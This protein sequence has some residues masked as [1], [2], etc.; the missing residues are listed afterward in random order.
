MEKK[1]LAIG[2]LMRILEA[3]QIK[4]WDDWSLSYE[5]IRRHDLIERAAEALFNEISSWDNIPSRYDI[6]CG[7]GNNG[8]DGLA[9]AR[10]LREQ[11]YNVSVILFKHPNE[12]SPEF[13]EQY[14]HWQNVSDPER[15]YLPDD[16]LPSYEKESPTVAVT[17]IDALLGNGINRKPEGRILDLIKHINQTY[18]R[19]ASIDLPSGL[20]AD[21]ET[22]YE[23]G[24]KIEDSVQA[25]ELLVVE[26]PKLTLLFPETAR[27]IPRWNL[28]SLSMSHEF[29]QQTDS[30]WFWFKADSLRLRVEDRF[31][32]KGN[33]LKLLLVGGQSGMAGAVTLAASAALETGIGLMKVL[34]VADARYSLMTH[35][36]EAILLPSPSTDILTEFPDPSEFGVVAIGPGLGTNPATGNALSTFLQKVKGPCLLDADALNLIAGILKDNPNFRF[37]EYSIITP[38]P[39]E[40]DRLWGE[41]AP[42]AWVRLQRA[43]TFSRKY[44]IVVVLKGAYTATILPDGKVI[45]NSGGSNK[46]ATA[47]TGDILTGMIAALLTRHHNLIEAAL[48]GVFLHSLLV[49]DGL[50]AQGQRAMHFCKSIAFILDQYGRNNEESWKAP[51]DFMAFF[52]DAFDQDNDEDDDED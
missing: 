29:D 40:F 8:A 41:K 23:H 32:H 14:F 27:H 25:S 12:C 17:A 38:H 30:P 51:D 20:P 47:G 15:T 7:C 52:S 5:G 13:K 31:I 36:P 6:Y 22:F 16:Q 48:F 21:P 28:V 46:L 43:R 37:P 2:S 42:N 11:D 35:A 19:I 44:Q 9:L 33:R 10:L 1:S 45:F 26:K 18:D 4:A 50:G 39:G 24:F 3:K 34:T 49:L